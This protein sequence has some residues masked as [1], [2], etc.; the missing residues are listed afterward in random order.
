MWRKYREEDMRMRKFLLLG[1]ILFLIIVTGCTGQQDRSVIEI[2]M[3]NPDGDVLGTAKLKEQPDAVEIK[4][5][6]EGLT[7]GLHGIHVHEYPKCEGPDFKSAG[8]HLDPEGKQHGLMNPEGAHLGDLPNLSADG[9]GVVDLKLMLPAATLYDGKNSILKEEGTSLI[10]HSGQDD[11]VSQPAGN[12]GE[13]VACGK[14]TLKEADKKDKA[15]DPVEKGEE[16]E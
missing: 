10:I 12:A 8:S 1:F 9:D 14:I 15:S 3:F 13:R 11:G 4:L 2:E 7:P 5:T 16:K 6:L